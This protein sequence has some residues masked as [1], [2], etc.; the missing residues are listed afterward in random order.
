MKAARPKNSIHIIDK[1]GL[2]LVDRHGGICIFGI[3]VLCNSAGI[4]LSRI[5][6]PE[7]HESH[8]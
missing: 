4:L 6:L 7:A 3:G 1:G 8:L 2:N 5:A